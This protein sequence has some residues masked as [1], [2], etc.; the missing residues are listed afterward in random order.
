MNNW[1]VLT[2]SAMRSGVRT[3]WGSQP[4][5]GGEAAVGEGAGYA[6]QPHTQAGESALREPLDSR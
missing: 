2:E 5:G 4:S 3:A 6:D 1:V